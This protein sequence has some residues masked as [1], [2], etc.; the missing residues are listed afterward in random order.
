M[1]ASLFLAYRS[2]LLDQ[3][4]SRDV[5][6]EGS[7]LIYLGRLSLAFHQGLLEAAAD[8]YWTVVWQTAL[9]HQ[10][11]M[12]QLANP[13]SPYDDRLSFIELLKSRRKSINMSE[14]AR[15]RKPI[16]QY[17]RTDVYARIKA[18]TQSSKF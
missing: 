13:T 10:T 2:G 16:G 7:Q 18:I 14:T 4:S 12:R 3:A 6:Q 9:W 1:A 5:R 8:W 11:R 15:T 17:P